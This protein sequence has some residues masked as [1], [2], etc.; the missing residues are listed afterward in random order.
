VGGLVLKVGEKVSYNNKIYTVL[1]IYCSGY[2]EIKENAYNVELVHRSKLE[3][4]K[5]QETK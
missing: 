4:E 3:L 1:H 2:C 5:E